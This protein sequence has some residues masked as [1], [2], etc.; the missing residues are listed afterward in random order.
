MDT[1]KK[2]FLKW[3]SIQLTMAWKAGQNR[4]YSCHFLNIAAVAD[5]LAEVNIFLDQG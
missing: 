3:K 5:T 2:I 4:L 1:L